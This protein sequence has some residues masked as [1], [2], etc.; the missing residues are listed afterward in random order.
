[1][2]GHHQYSECPECGATLQTRR[3]KDN[4]IVAAR[5]TGVLQFCAVLV[6]MIVLCIEWA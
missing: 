2:A 1:M 5:I 3:M 6:L 4:T